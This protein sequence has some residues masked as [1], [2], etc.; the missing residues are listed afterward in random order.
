[1]LREG[2]GWGRWERA[3]R[4]SGNGEREVAFVR[5]GIGPT[6]RFEGS[7]MGVDILG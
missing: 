1:M 5:M 4:V 6:E 3:L 7:K 2:T